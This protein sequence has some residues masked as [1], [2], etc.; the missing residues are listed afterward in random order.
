MFQEERQN[1]ILEIVKEKDSV[2]VAELSEI[3]EISGVTIRKDLDEL[4]ERG[5]LIRTHGGAVALQ[6]VSEA[7]SVSDLIKNNKNVEA[8]RRIA[9]IAYQHIEDKQ[10]I[11]TDGSS[12]VYELAKL[13]AGGNKKNIQIITTSLLI[14]DV[15]ENNDNITT[16]MLAGKINYKHKTVLGQL[17]ISLV[18][19]MRVDKC[20]V[21]MNGIEEEFGLSSPDFE[22]SEL[23]AA[24]IKSSR[25]SYVLA[26][27]SKFG[28]TYLAKV[29]ANPN[30]IITSSK[31]P[32]FD[33]EMLDSKVIVADEE[34]VQE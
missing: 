17:T 23:K 31:I 1:R 19:S 26:D 2:K 24:M 22:E 3:L 4:S 15:F 11:F 13:I 27:D 32:D 6:S 7:I 29:D 20:F 34:N 8:K 9:K 28:R 33:Y 12:T 21:G 16:I 18:N 25:E 14:A 5:K 30:Y 10:T